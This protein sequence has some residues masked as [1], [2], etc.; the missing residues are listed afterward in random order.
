MKITSPADFG[1]RRTSNGSI[2]DRVFYDIDKSGLPDDDSDPGINNVVVNLRLVL[3][4][5]NGAII[6][7][8]IVRQRRLP[9]RHAGGR[10]L[11]RQ[12][13]ESTGRFEF[14]DQQ[15]PRPSRS[16]R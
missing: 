6:G 8:R 11:L 9:V 7:T 16:G 5:N 2:G 13:D 15:Q 10:A 14:D 4:V 3:C 1:Y 12:V